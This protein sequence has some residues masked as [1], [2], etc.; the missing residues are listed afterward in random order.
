MR[1]LRYFIQ[2]AFVSLRRSGLSGLLAVLTIALALFVF[3]AFVLVTSSL[4][5][6]MAGW[7]T[8]SE[9]SVYLRDDITDDQRAAVDASLAASAL[10][11]SRQSVS[12]AEA[13][14]R[15]TRDFPDLA[16][17]AGS[18]DA[19]PFPASFDVRLRPRAVSTTDLARFARTL[20]QAEGV[21]DVR[22][23]RQWLERLAQLVGAVRWA[24]LVLATALAIAAAFTVAAVVR[25]A[26]DGRRDEVEIM[27]LVGAPMSAIRGPFIVEGVL[28]GGFGGVLAIFVLRGVYAIVA[29]RL[30]PAAAALGPDV[31]Q[32]LSL[33]WSA[34]IVAGGMVVGCFGGLVAARD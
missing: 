24:G 10:V 23:D 9:L 3:G 25:L 4:D 5:R 16:G 13:I 33:G 31:V 30:G 28:Q 6:L 12:K 26:M 20:A 19:N 11:E 17:V 27:E 32:F 1:A 22:Y 14:R 21:A 34:A 7:N 15:F 29:A 18:L 2:E 8:V